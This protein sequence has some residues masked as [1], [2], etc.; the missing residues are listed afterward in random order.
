MVQSRML[1]SRWLSGAVVTQPII[2]AGE[3]FHVDNTNGSNSNSGK[4]WAHALSTLNYAISL[5]EDDAGDVIYLAPYHSETI[6]ATGTASSATTDECVIDKCGIQIVGL[7]HGNFRPTFSLGIATSAAFVVTAAT[8]NIVIDNIILISAYA[9]VA[10]GIT[11][12][13]T[14]VGAT[15]QNCTL[16]SGIGNS[17]ELVN[18][19]TIAADC[20]DVA[21]INNVFSTEEGNCETAV[22]L[23]G[24]CDRM[25][26]VGNYM[27]GT[28][29]TATFKA[30]A[31]TSLDMTI[32]HNVF[33]NQGQYTVN[34]KTD[35]TGVLAHNTIGGTTSI[36]DALIGDDAMYCW[37]NYVTGEDGGSG[38]LNPSV[39]S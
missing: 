24:G 17:L 5:C 1:N 16:R 39:A 11:L 27:H 23:A 3:V 22:I 13:A 34:L 6:E 12:D 28:Y 2:A 8:T 14:A 30:S 21:L 32:M 37:E 7:G 36:A 33:A 20:D 38:A 10:A 4:D 26:V 35:C 31:N 9:D 29:S 19:I 18:G 25:K 15:I